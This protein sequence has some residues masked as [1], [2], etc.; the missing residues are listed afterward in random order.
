MK[1]DNSTILFILLGV[2]GTT[3]LICITMLVYK[4]GGDIQLNT[5]VQLAVLSQIP[6]A[7]VATLSTVATILKI[8]KMETTDTE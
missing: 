6:V 2:I 5:L 7:V 1:F 4:H 8:K 3:G